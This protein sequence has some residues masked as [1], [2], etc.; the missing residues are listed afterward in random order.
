MPPSLL[1]FDIDGTL[2]RGAPPVHR[3]ALCEAAL[4]T[5]GV[6]LTA[7][8]LGQTAGMTDTA[9]ARR[10][11]KWAGVDDATITAGLPALCVA[12]ADAYDRLAPEDLRAYQTPSAVTSLEWARRRGIALGLVTGNI[13]RIARRKL[14][15]AGL[16]R[17]F[18]LEEAPGEAAE[19]WAWIGGFGDAAEDRNAL[20]PLALRRATLLLGAPPHPSATWVIG[21]TPADIACGLANGL[22]T[23]AVA[24]GPVHSLD[25]LL[26]HGPDAAIRDLGALPALLDA[27][28]DSPG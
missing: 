8:D 19:A 21:D 13:E 11:L 2:V 12:A 4:H 9:I 20:P 10:A 26:A 16:A 27:A 15:A 24:T 5:F 25:E 7:E 18:A 1:L 3:L 22:R 17:Y 6:H 14:T 28:H 23:A